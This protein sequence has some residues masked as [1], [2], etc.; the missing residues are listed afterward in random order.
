[1]NSSNSK[2]RHYELD[3]GDGAWSTLRGAKAY[4]LQVYTAQDVR[5]KKVNYIIGTFTYNTN[6]TKT[7]VI[8]RNNR[9]GFGLPIKN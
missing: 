8:I 9:I 2:C 5:E 1:M 4:V 7:P 6:V 3:N